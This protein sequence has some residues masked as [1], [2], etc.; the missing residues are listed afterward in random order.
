MQDVL[1]PLVKRDR[2]KDHPALEQLP[3]YE[4]VAGLNAS[5]D[6]PVDEGEVVVT[7]H[8]LLRGVLGWRMARSSRHRHTRNLISMIMVLT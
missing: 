8:D 6:M 5:L 3:G 1:E 7:L 2:E 4:L